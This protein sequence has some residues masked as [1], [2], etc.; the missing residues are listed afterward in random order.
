MSTTLPGPRGP[1]LLGQAFNLDT[2]HMHLQ[3]LDWQKRYGDIFMFKVLGKHYM[4]VSHPDIIKDMFI[5]CPHANKLNDR[6]VSFM[7]SHV[8]RD[9]KDIVFRNC[10][11]QQRCLKEATMKYIENTL[12][13]EAWFYDDIKDEVIGIQEDIR[14]A[15]DKP[16]DIL[17]AMDRASIR[18]IGYLISGSAVKDS[19]EQFQSLTDFMLKGRLTNWTR[20]EPDDSNRVPICP[21]IPWS[22]GTSYDGVVEKRAKLKQ[23]FIKENKSGRGLVNMLQKLGKTLSEEKGE[24]WLDED[25]VM[26]VIMDL[27]AAAVVPLQNTLSVLFLILL[28]YPE[29]Q[30]KIRAEVT[31]VS[32][33]A[34]PSI[35]DIANMPY[36]HACMLE[37]KRF[38]TPLPISARHCPRSGNVK[39]GK[40]VIPKNTE[41]FSNLFGL[42]HDERFWEQPW[43]F[44]PE[45]FLTDDGKLISDDH[46]NMK[47]LIATGV[48]PRACVG[49]KFSENVM[50]LL[51]ADLLRTVELSPA[52]DHPLPERDPRTFLPG[53]VTRSPAFVCSCRLVE[54]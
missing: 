3:F 14:S 47:N 48:G 5:T 26:G 42:N 18:I 49:A 29:V 11:A 34:A 39:F 15:I 30:A 53:V 7:G 10:D 23:F 28:H 37:L 52:A 13:S 12:M 36:T 32:P 24:D 50:L 31:Q 6:A 16:F 27:T 44:M 19:D 51:T 38:H 17:E 22:P 33:N 9:T 46:D 35:G 21:E 1:P 54:T 43:E 2:S 45:R 20:Q 41:I 25:F 40:Y 8:I 4:V